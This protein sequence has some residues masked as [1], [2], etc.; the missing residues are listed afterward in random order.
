MSDSW[1]PTDGYGR[2]LC[3][4]G[5]VGGSNCRSVADSLGGRWRN[6][7]TWRGARGPAG[8]GPLITAASAEAPARH[9][10][11]PRLS[12]LVRPGPSSGS[13]DDQGDLRGDLQV[14]EGVETAVDLEE[15]RGLPSGDDLLDQRDPFL[16]GLRDVDLNGA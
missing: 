1:P 8:G 10:R 6:F 16:A 3:G 7:F 4:R 12:H 2:R 5:Q 13:L 14:H 11:P 15:V 9:R